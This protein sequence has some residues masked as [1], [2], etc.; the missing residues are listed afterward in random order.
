MT[1]IRR[2]RSLAGA[3]TIALTGVPV[4]SAATDTPVVA[5]DT[6]TAAGVFAD[7]PISVLD[8]LKTNTRLD[9]LDY[10]RADSIWQAPNTMG[11]TS[12]LDKVT[13]DYLNVTLTSVSNLEIKIL[14]VKNG[15]IAMT[16]YT[17]GKPDGASDSEV[18]F[19]DSSMRL[20]PTERYFK[21]PDLKYFLDIPKGVKDSD[22]LSHIPFPSIRLSASSESDML[23]GVMTLGPYM[24]TEDL[25]AVKPYLRPEVQWKWDGRRFQFIKPSK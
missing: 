5:A 16:V 8:L 23:T 12:S 20:L 9:M 4:A 25:D 15:A 3:L 1:S 18:R 7:L 14:P 13:P 22:L 11:G 2:L 10:F 24:P 17:V 21:L 6:L 19:F